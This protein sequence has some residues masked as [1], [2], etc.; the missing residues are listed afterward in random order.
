VGCI[1]GTLLTKPEEDEV[2]MK[3]Y[4]QV[5]PW[6]FWK[7]IHQKV[8][9]LDPAF[10]S[11]ANFKRDMFNVAVGIVWQTSLVALPIFIVVREKGSMVSALAILL[12]SSLVLRKTWWKNITD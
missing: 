1:L 11:D 8:L 2:L 6:G 10:K 4:K 7:P 12:V 9:Q 5:R 3:F